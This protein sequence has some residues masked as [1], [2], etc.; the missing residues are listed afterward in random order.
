MQKIDNKYLRRIVYSIQFLMSIV[1]LATMYFIQ[2]VPMKYFISAVVVLLVF[3]VGEYFLIFYKKKEA[4][5]HY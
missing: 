2:F 4:N 5:A 1:L 3:M